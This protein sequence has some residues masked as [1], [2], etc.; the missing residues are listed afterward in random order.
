MHD[1][2]L[3]TERVA[4]AASRRGVM[5]LPSIPKNTKKKICQNREVES[6][7]SVRRVEF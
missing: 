4:Q 1:S 6:L 5:I 2:T 3:R 7:F